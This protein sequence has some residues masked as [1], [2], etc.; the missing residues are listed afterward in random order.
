M[1]VRSVASTTLP[2]SCVLALTLAGCTSSPFDLD[3]PGTRPLIRDL[4][5]HAAPADPQRWS[6][7]EAGPA[8]SGELSLRD[9]LAAALLHNPRLHASAWGPRVEE[10]TRLQAGLRPNPEVGIEFENFAGSGELSGAD[11]LETT[12]MLSQLIELGGKRKARVRV[13]E[14][15]WQVSVLDYEAERLAVLTETAMRFVRVL[16]IQHR[17]QLAERARDLAEE[18]RR[19]IDRRV[20]A[21]DVSPIDEIKARLESESARITADRLQRDLDAARRDLSAMWNQ[22]DPTYTTLIGS[23]D[24]LGPNP[25]LTELSAMIDAHPQVQRWAAEADRLAA[26]VELERARGVPDVNAGLGVRYENEIEDAAL[27]AGM[28]VPLPLF[29]RNQ[30]GILAARL[31]ASQAIDEGR[32]SR[33][34]LTTRLNRAHARLSAAYHEAQAISDVLLPAAHNAYEAT[35]RAYEEGKV[36]YLNVLDA[37]RTLF[38]TEAQR[39]EALAEYHTALVEVEGLIATPLDAVDS[40]HTPLP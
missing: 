33:R 18:S 28:S 4:P 35:R 5:R 11:A 19:V 32:A 39:L 27:V 24:Q 25:S 29:D 26:A 7:T 23:L 37:Q 22:D 34:E 16:E 9:A 40:G 13:A 3:L 6:R 12:L 38:D 17:L 10:A 36:A 31:R 15:A 8:V 20:Q 21:G 14:G 30:G 2:L 1:F